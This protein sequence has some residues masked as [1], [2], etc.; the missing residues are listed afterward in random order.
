MTDL[1]AVLAKTPELSLV[2]PLVE[3]HRRVDVYRAPDGLAAAVDVALWLGEPLL[4]TGDPGVGKTRAAYWLASQLNAEPLLVYNVKSTSS[5]VDLLYSFDE[6]S[7]FRETSTKPLIRYLRFNGLGEAILRAAGGR[8]ILRTGSG[9]PLD[10]P[11]AI[12][13]HREALD[14]AFGAD[15]WNV[16]D[17]AVRVAALLPRDPAFATAPGRHRVLLLDEL[18]KAPR[19]TPNDLLSEVETLSFRIAE[20]D[21]EVS[22]AE[23]RRPV[24]VITSNSEKSLPDPFLRRCVYFDIPFPEDDLAEIVTQSIGALE[25]G[26]PMLGEAIKLFL[27][28]RDPATGLRKRPGTAELLAW[29]DTLVHVHDFAPSTPFYGDPEAIKG[30]LS[31]VLKTKEDLELG[32]RLVDQSAKQTG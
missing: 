27:K 14:K 26:G 9:V 13:E 28:L 10:N 29:L 7:R 17:D 3:G 6:V 32:R 20:L 12:A 23:G 4:L 18:D 25:G 8:T 24:I 30:S 19:D 22:C 1:T 31:A 15:G 11:A 5:G 16:T 2:P 21:L